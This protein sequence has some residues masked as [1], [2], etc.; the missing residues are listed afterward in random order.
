MKQDW[1]SFNRIRCEIRIPV[2][3]NSLG[4]VPVR[5]NS[6]YWLYHSPFRSDVHPSFSVKLAANRW[7][8][9][10]MGVSGSVIDLAMQLGYGST[11][12]EAA[13]YL[14]KHYGVGGNNVAPV[15]PKIADYP[16]YPQIKSVTTLS[17]PTLL[18]YITT[19]RKIPE[20]IAVEY[21]KEIRYSVRGREYYAIAFEN[22]SHGYE[23]RSSSWK[24]ALSPKDITVLPG[25]NRCMCFVFEGFM[26]FLSCVALYGSCPCDVIVLNS[27]SMLGKAIEA[28]R[29]Y[30]HIKCFLDNDAPGRTAF[31]TILTAF[32]AAENCSH[33]YVNFKDMNEYLINL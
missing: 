33:I 9:F 26:D 28:F 1:I 15:A 24:G 12:R 6:D 21:C 14:D 13:L 2:V 29:Y 18:Q 32:P 17:H 4:Y 30:N 23:L 10:T 3:M 25:L 31:N 20:G 8:D 16:H 11:A 7:C 27:I 22:L 5:Q 19:N